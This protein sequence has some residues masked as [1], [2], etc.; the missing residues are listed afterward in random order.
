[1][2]QD[3]KEI[4]K[5]KED[6]AE[7]GADSQTEKD[8][9]DESVAAQERRE[10]AITEEQRRLERQVRKWRTEAVENKG[11]DDKK[12]KQARKKA[13]EANKAYIDF[14]IKHDRAFYP[15]RTKI[16]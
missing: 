3:E 13:I 7:K 4:E 14:S 1:M 15:S 6:I 8:R 12:Y 16:I 9:I 10:Y 11:Q 2:T 5:A